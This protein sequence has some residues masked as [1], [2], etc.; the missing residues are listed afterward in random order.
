MISERQL[1]D[2]IKKY[3]GQALG[4][5]DKID[6]VDIIGTSSGESNFIF[7]VD[8]NNLPYLIKIN[9][10]GGKDVSFFH[11][12]YDKLKSLERYQIAPRAFVYDDASFTFPFMVLE[13]YDGRTLKDTECDKRADE[14]VS[15]INKL[16]EIP[17]HHIMNSKGFKR[18]IKS[19]REYVEIFP[20]YA[21]SQLI[22]YERRI[23]RDE[24]YNLVMKAH[25]NAKR[26][27]GESLNLFD[28]AKLG[29]I[30]TG[31]HPKNIILSSN[32]TLRLIDWEHA[33]VGDR[34]FEISS[35]FRS[36]QLSQEKILDIYKGK[37]G[38]FERRVNLYTELFKVHGVL[39]HAIRVDKVRKGEIQLTRDKDESYYQSLLEVH[40]KNLH[41]SKL[42]N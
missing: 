30:H 7:F 13:R 39:W 27:I 24:T 15:I 25:Y 21:N 8:I 10:V 17:P 19:C 26:L 22:E 20:K 1:I 2:R 36:N 3:P 9:G 29:L 18:D 38:L 31:I 40:V 42:S 34:A 35:L 37:T 28:G 16:T 41:K 11:A 4:L 32:N 5:E 33:G 14:L 12:E 23:G 6:N